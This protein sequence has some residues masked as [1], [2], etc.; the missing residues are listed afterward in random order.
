MHAVASHSSTEG[1]D[2]ALRTLLQLRAPTDGKDSQGR[3]P[4]HL[5]VKRSN[6]DAVLT[7]L[8]H[9]ADP[10]ILDE[11][12]DTAL[13]VATRLNKKDMAQVLLSH[14]A[15]AQIPRLTYIVQRG[16]AQL[17]E[18]L[19]AARATLPD[20]D[21]TGRT[22]LGHAADR[23]HV[24]VLK[25]LLEQRADIGI[26]DVGSGRTSLQHAV[27]RGQATASEM[28][29]Q[30]R[31]SL[32]ARDAEGQAAIHFLKFDIP[33]PGARMEVMQLLLRH[34]ADATVKDLE[35]E[36]LAMTLCNQSSDV[37]FELLRALATAHG[38]QDLC[39]DN[40]GP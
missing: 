16:H 4:L 40:L 13:S 35:G 10:N 17:L 9:R 5:A 2:L 30:S 34:R 36:T 1:V 26:E 8:E 31:A 14:G 11:R 3:T 27:M 23:G 29:L 15:D 18:L 21:H 20:F 24:S 37:A 33:I 32:E 19:M 22:I 38:Q 39:K 6:S 25:L 7:L 28:L 12:D